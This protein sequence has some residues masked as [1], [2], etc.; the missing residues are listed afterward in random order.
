MLQKHGS[1]CGKA[2]EKLRSMV[3]WYADNLENE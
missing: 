1:N 3:E 2:I